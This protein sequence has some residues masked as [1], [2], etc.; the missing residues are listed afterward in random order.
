MPDV[1]QQCREPNG[2]ALPFSHFGELAALIQRCEREAREVIRAQRML[3]S[4]MGGAGIDEEGMAELADVAKPL[5]RCGVQHGQR[6]RVEADV[7]PERVANDLEVAR[8]QSSSRSSASRHCSGERHRLD[9]IS[10]RI[11]TN[12]LGSRS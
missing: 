9:R 12:S 4:G 7:V 6:R 10:S 3:E 5:H 1:V 2:L 11:S 8:G